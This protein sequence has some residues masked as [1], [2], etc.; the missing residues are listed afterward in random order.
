[1]NNSYLF[2]LKNNKAN[3]YSL[4]NEEDV[5]IVKFSEEMLNAARALHPK[6][7]STEYI[8]DII[9]ASLKTQK[10][11]CWNSLNLMARSR[12]FERRLIAPEFRKIYL[13]KLKNLTKTAKDDRTLGECYAGLGRL[14]ESSVIPQVVHF[15]LN[16]NGNSF[17]RAGAVY[18]LS[19]FPSEEQKNALRI[20]MGNA[21][22]KMVLDRA[23]E[24]LRE[25]QSAP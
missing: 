22:D 16:G 25:L 18:W 14:G 9:W 11:E 4:K 21:K 7:N 1:L 23:S 13:E 17:R 2:F 8:L 24:R 3:A 5:A 20:I 12:I 6:E 10:D 19:T 15:I